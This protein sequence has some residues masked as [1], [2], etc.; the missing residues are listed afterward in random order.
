MLSLSRVN[1]LY[2]CLKMSPPKDFS[3]NFL[4][5]HIGTRPSSVH[6]VIGMR[7]VKLSEGGFRVWYGRDLNV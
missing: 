1:I 4:V 7:T 3:G 5:L 6:G 2:M